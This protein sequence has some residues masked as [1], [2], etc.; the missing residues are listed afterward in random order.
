M[1]LATLHGK[2][3]KLGLGPMY[4]KHWG[5]TSATCSDRG[6]TSL[7]HAEDRPD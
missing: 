6:A 7:P 5:A 1:C 2:A 4:E 3:R